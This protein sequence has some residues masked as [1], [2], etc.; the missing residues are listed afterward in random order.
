MAAPP[1]D[2]PVLTQA[3]TGHPTDRPSRPRLPIIPA[4]PRKL[5]K[6]SNNNSSMIAGSK[7]GTNTVPEPPASCPIPRTN[8][9]SQDGPSG[10]APR[11]NSTSPS[12]QTIE[13]DQITGDAIPAE[14]DG[15][16]KSAQASPIEIAK[17]QESITDISPGPPSALD[18][19]TPPFV[20]EASRT[21]PQAVDTISDHYGENDLPPK[22]DDR[23]F[24]Y[25]LQTTVPWTPYH[26]TPP[27]ESVQPPMQESYRSYG[28]STPLFYD[29]TA[30]YNHSNA[31]STVYYGHGQ[32]PNFSFYP[33]SSQSYASNS[34]AQSAYEGYAM[35]N[36]PHV[37]HSRAKAPSHQY[38]PSPV[39]RLSNPAYPAFQPQAQYPQS[40]PQFGSQFPITPSATPSNSGSQKQEPSQS[41]VI[42]RDTSAYQANAVEAPE[43]GRSTKEIS[44]EY[45]DWC[46]RTN[47]ALK[48]GSESSAR[49]VA[50]INHLIDNFNN[51]AF[52]DCELYISH[53]SHRFEPAVV[54]LHSLLIAQNPKLRDLL[55][56]AEIREDGKKQILL[57]VEDQYTTPAALKIAIKVCYGE[58]PAQYIGYPGGLASESEISTAWMDNALALAAAGH[59]LGLTG[60]AHR[61]E[62]IASMVLDWHNLEQAL[63]FVVDSNVRRAWGSSTG[64]SSFPCNASELLLSCLYF[65]ISNVSESMSLDIT[66]KAIPSIDRLPV[67]P[68]SEAQ[69]SKSRLSQIRFG[70]L[71]IETEEPGN[72]HDV[73]IS[74]IL[75]S[76][77]FTLLKFVLDRIPLPVN[78][79]V[80]EPLVG[81]RERRR[82][83]A[84]HAPKSTNQANSDVEPALIREERLVESGGEGKGRF[85]LET[86]SA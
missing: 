34:P 23:Q 32:F 62:Q 38:A 13:S 74:S 41:D 81:E 51:P 24:P 17:A 64:S 69:S 3:A 4:I 76:L 30:P 61:G 71:P 78:R 57:A 15:P 50:L 65:I 11:D 26:T 80:A 66:A 6:R 54:S 29:P 52:A 40:I 56:V 33:Q 2:A 46:D 9:S 35:A 25:P 72:E 73:L 86:V 1:R 49:S 83:H 55:Q 42:D 60:V 36:T 27:D 75:M 63:S 53:V 19:Q 37:I 48:E 14:E 18:P 47:H 45:R 68:D 16:T 82:L 59:L 44:R 67:I 58:R 84:S 31:N 77:P 12:K 20:P 79:N 7:S 5:E 70:D 43:Q 39:P 21:S 10:S 22:R 85:A 8:E 28:E